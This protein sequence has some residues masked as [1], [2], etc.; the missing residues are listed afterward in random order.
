M[1]N[2]MMMIM[3]FLI[4]TGM[5]LFYMSI[6]QLNMGEGMICSAASMMVLLFL[7]AFFANTF[8]Y[9]MLGIYLLSGIG[10]VCFVIQWICKKNGQLLFIGIVVWGILACLF[11][12]GLVIYHNDFIQHTDEFHLWAALVKYMKEKDRLPIGNDFIAGPG[13]IYLSSSLFIAFFQIFAGYNEGNMYVAS[14][15]LTF[16]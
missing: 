8:R 16:I 12:V 3:A 15:L 7:S 1:T 5:A 9:G 10:A 6:L 4:V 14:T 2:I 11:V 13:Q